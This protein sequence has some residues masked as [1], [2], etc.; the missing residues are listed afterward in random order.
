LILILKEQQMAAKNSGTVAAKV[1][2]PPDLRAAL[3]E[4]PKAAAVFDKFPPSHKLEY[5]K[6][7]S[8]AKRDETRKRRVA[9]ALE[10]MIATSSVS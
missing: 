10:R 1:E 7:I 5:V 4:H 3:L 2:V 9:A 8:E 6:W